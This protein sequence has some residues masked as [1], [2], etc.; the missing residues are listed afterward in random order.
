MGHKQAWECDEK[1]GSLVGVGPNE[2]RMKEFLL[3]L[4]TRV[5]GSQTGL[6][7]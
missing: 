1:R 2:S 4:A 7:V 3:L 5:D 6:G